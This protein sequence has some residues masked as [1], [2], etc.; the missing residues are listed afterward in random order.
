LKEFGRA[1]ITVPL[2]VGGR[3]EDIFR[4]PDVSYAGDV[5]QITRSEL[6]NLYNNRVRKLLFRERPKD[7]VFNGER[8]QDAFDRI[9]NQ[10]EERSSKSATNVLSRSNLRAIGLGLEFRDMIAMIAD[11]VN[12]T[13]PAVDPDD[14]EAIRKR[15]V[16]GI[17][18]SFASG[19]GIFKGSLEDWSFRPSS[20]TTVR[21]PF[22][23]A[24]PKDV[25]TQQLA[26]L[27]YVPLKDNRLRKIPTLYLEIDLIRIFRI[28]DTEKS[29]GADFYLSMSDENNPNIDTIE[30]ANAFLDPK[31]N[32]RQIS[33]QVLHEG[34]QSDIYPKHMKVYEVSGKFM[35]DPSYKNYP[36]DVQRFTIELRPKKGEFPFI[37][38]PLQAELRNKQ[39]DAEGWESKGEYVSYDQ[40]FIPIVDTRTLESRIIPF[41]KGSFVWVLKR[42]AN[43]YFLRVV[44]PLCFIMIVAY[45]AIFISTSRF[46]S[47]ANIQVTALLSAVA[48]YITTPKV[49]SD[50]ATLSDS[51]FVFNYMIL[52]LMIG[53]SILRVNGLVANTL[54]LKRALAILHVVFIPFFVAIMAFYIAGAGG[55]ESQAELQFRTALQDGFSRFFV[56]LTAIV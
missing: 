16:S 33:I 26:A 21:T 29:F 46:E 12:S 13:K 1:G 50:T 22:I 39:F 15:I 3:L 40:D 9:E 31:N 43:D 27:Q 11:I 47:I 34:V 7:W 44:V 53:I 35:L 8:N 48:L 17:P 30:F 37:I 55:S 41:Y 56:W 51:I 6:P 14:I 36:F 10:C 28:D 54:H 5:Y 23:I 42:S 32:T 4:S 20:R 18:Q 19:K 25:N 45:L 52:C 24:R 49:D 2:F 38:Q